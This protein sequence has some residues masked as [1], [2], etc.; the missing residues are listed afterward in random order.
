MS[1]C[2]LRRT[3]VN[4]N[5]AS[6][7]VIYASG[8]QLTM[9]DAQ[10]LVAARERTPFK[11]NSDAFKLLPSGTPAPAQGPPEVGVASRFFEVRA[12]LRLNDLVVEERSV[13][14]RSAPGGRSEH[15][16]PRT[17]DR[18]SHGPVPGRGQAMSR[19]TFLQSSIP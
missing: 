6:A 17:R 4:L 16:G 9:A 13:I 18:R 11:T 7:E 2:C 3:A 14:E 19:A 15:A 10:R 12:R 5:T 1:P 8:H